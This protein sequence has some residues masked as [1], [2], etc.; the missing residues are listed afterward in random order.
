MYLFIHTYIYIYICIYTRICNNIY[1]GE[2]S[3]RLLAMGLSDRLLYMYLYKYTYICI[4]ICIYI[5]VY[6]YTGESSARLLAMGLSDSSY[7]DNISDDAEDIYTNDT[8]SKQDIKEKNLFDIDNKSSTKN[9]SKE[10]KIKD[11]KSSKNKCIHKK[12]DISLHDISKKTVNE[13]RYN[14]KH[15][16]KDDM[17]DLYQNNVNL[18]DFYSLKNNEKI[19]QNFQ[20]FHFLQTIKFWEKLCTIS[21]LLGSV[22]R[23][24]ECL[25]LYL[26]M[27]MYIC[28]YELCTIFRL[29]GGIKK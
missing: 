14:S 22:K 11:T 19:N 24:F 27:Y 10:I 8:E 1:T 12:N 20:N 25:I 29:L 28:I 21:R 3:V 17:T 26:Y 5:Y 9:I 7:V 2:S 23:L 16:K 18:K 15:M 6:I 13:F 4:H